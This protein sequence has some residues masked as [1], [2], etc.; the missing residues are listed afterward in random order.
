M[1]AGKGVV[2]SDLDREQVTVTHQAQCV[3][4]LFSGNLGTVLLEGGWEGGV[5]HCD[6]SRAIGLHTLM[7]FGQTNECAL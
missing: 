6:H 7:Q 2:G 4:L 3:L 5:W 1:W